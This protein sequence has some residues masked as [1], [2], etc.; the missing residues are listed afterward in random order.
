MMI[1]SGSTR[2][3]AVRCLIFLAVCIGLT[4]WFAYDGYVVYPRKNLEK[5]R[6]NFPRT[7]TGLPQADARVTEERC[8]QLQA[9]LP[10]SLDGLV[11]QLGQPAYRDETQAHFVGPYGVIRA[12]LEGDRVL[13]IVWE[14][15]AKSRFEIQFQRWIAWLLGLLSLATLV[16]FVRILRTRVVVDDQGLDYNGRRIS[17]DQMT[18]LETH[19]YAEK[20]WVDLHYQPQEPDKPSKRLRLDSYK[21]AAFEPIVSAICERKG[22]PNPFGGADEADEQQAQPQ[23]ETDSP[24]RP[25]A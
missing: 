16:Q 11:S 20:G 2:D 1:E 10:A 5:A 7:T 23:G 19:Q 9:K 13:R 12:F 24:T 6:E 17:W 8:K 3:R 21:I 25:E 18:G 15:L 22:F 4:I 14:E